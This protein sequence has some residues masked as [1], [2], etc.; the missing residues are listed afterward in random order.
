MNEFFLQK[1]SMVIAFMKTRDEQGQ[2][3]L[4]YIGM[5]FVAALLVAAVIAGLGGGKE[6]TGAIKEG[7]AKVISNAGG[8]KG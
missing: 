2:G 3:T 4:E 1:Y 6:I 8:G 7:I 5:V